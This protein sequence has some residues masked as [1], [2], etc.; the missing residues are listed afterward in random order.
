MTQETKSIE[1][2]IP[3]YTLR[4]PMEMG[5]L[6]LGGVY[7]GEKTEEFRNPYTGEIDAEYFGNIGDH[8]IAVAH[9]AEILAT[10][11]SGYDN[12]QTKNIIRR[13]LVHDATKRFEVMRK[14]ALKQGLIEDV[15]STRAYETIR[16]ILEQ[17]GVS[18]DVIQYM[19]NAGAE[20][21]HNSL[22]DFIEIKDGVPVLK[23]EDNLAE[24]IVHLA[25]DMTHTS[26]AKPGEVAQTQYLTIEER[27][28]ASD[29]PN[30]YP[31]IYK[32]GFGFDEN[33]KV[34]FVKDAAEENLG[35]TNVRTYADWQVWVAR[36]MSKY[37]VGLISPKTSPNDAEQFLKNLVNKS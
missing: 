35:L 17:Q 27:M 25:D 4:F 13:A 9:C 23:T 2:I 1:R 34:V 12:P 30:R 19:A 24:M 26:F 14:K 5:I 31:F 33:G 37:L 8:C 18:S 36:E 29:F 20:T 21:G 16:P 11:V 7:P 22:K 28:V 15:Y 32:E 6:R 10:S 3:E